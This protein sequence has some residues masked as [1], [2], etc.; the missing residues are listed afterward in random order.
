MTPDPI[1]SAPLAV[2]LHLAAALPAVLLGPVVLF[3]NSRDRLHKVLGYIWIAAIVALS[4]TGLVIPSEFP[5]IGP[6]GPIHLFSLFALR[7]VGEGWFHIRRGDV[8]GHLAAMQSVWFGAVGLAG[9]FTLMPGRTLNRALFGEPS[10]AG[11]LAM[12]IGGAILA[13]L[14][15]RR[16]RWPPPA[17]DAK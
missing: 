2:Q 17:R 12:A 9:L 14:W 4:V 5:L 7:G 1:L 15:R 13:L 6:F 11:F 3:R 16:L 8:A 10:A